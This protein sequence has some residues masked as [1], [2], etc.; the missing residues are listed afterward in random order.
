MT[1]KNNKRLNQIIPLPCPSI[2][3]LRGRQSVRAT[4]KLTARAISVLNTVSIHLGIK[5]KS[6]FDHL[7]EDCQTLHSIAKKLEMRHFN[8]LQ[9]IQKTFVLSRKTLASLCEAAEYSG[10]P[11]D[12]IV[13]YSIYR[14]ESVLSDELKKQ[15]IRKQIQSRLA[16]QIDNMKKILKDSQKLLGNGD[17]LCRSLENM[18][19]ACISAYNDLGLFVN[20]GK[21]IEDFDYPSS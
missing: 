19:D 6:L 2:S 13:E 15:K 9:R 21:I 16:E 5:Q 3:D 4:F 11:R 12:A 14:L 8:A 1:I 7:M 20:K 18:T 10:A 17:P